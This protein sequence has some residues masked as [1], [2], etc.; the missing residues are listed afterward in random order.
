M[1]EVGAEGY[2][3]PEVIERLP[4]Y[5]ILRCNTLTQYEMQGYPEGTRIVQRSDGGFYTHVS[6]MMGRRNP[7]EVYQDLENQRLPICKNCLVKMNSLIEGLNV[8]TV[9]SFRIQD[10]FDAGFQATWCNRGQYSKERGAFADIYPKDWLAIAALRKEQAQYICEDCDADL[11][12]PHHRGR[13]FIHSSDH[14]SGKISYSK[15]RCVCEVCAQ[16]HARV[17]SGPSSMPNEPVR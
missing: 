3:E 8:F 12:D 6:T 14:R 17:R 1:R 4:Q 11:S 9:R 15:L 13:T 10:F 2:E 16:E 5:H 7:E